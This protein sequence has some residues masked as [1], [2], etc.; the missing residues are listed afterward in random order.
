MSPE[1]EANLKTSRAQFNKGNN[2]APL[3]RRW[4]VFGVLAYLSIFTGGIVL[5]A[6]WLPHH[7]GR[8]IAI[9]S[10][11]FA[12]QLIFLARHLDLN[13]RF[14][15]HAPLPT[16]GLGTSF[17]MLRGVMI[18]WTA[19]FI[20]SPRPPS[21]LAW[22]PAVLYT[23]AILLDLMDG[24][25]ARVE[26]HLTRLGAALD[27]ELDALGLLVGVSLAVWYGILPPLF[28]LVGVARYAFQ[29]GIWVRMRRSLPVFELPRSASR[30]P[31]AGLTMGF[32]SAMLWP[33]VTPPG[34]I[35]AGLIF[36][37]PFTASFG[38]DW[39]VVSGWLDPN[40]TG[41]LRMRE[42]SRRVILRWMPLFVRI[43]L[44]AWMVVAVTCKMKLFDG[45]TPVP[46]L[47]LASPEVL[48][49]LGLLMIVAGFAGRLVAFVLIFP[50][51]FAII[52]QGLTPELIFLL[53]LNL[54][55]LFIGTGI[56]TIWEPEKRMFGR[57]W[58]ER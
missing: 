22:A 3:K 44:L 47:P 53:V 39:L 8:W 42:I 1:Q 28:L 36:L 33:I 46:R 56:Y 38:R 17:T 35:I 57:R 40:D 43:V 52:A 24:Y 19:G 6:L 15:D 18:A 41:Y 34:S 7:A 25:A 51:S 29:L 27:T 30:R 20:L 26:D 9:T 37:V 23:T 49:W 16:F 2:L 50:I 5:G 11:V 55:I 45:A 10:G 12:Y 31:I 21:L 32:T 4:V 14:R 13:H 48:L 58:G 54:T